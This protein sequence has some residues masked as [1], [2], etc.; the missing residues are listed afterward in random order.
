[1]RRREID[2]VIVW[3]LDHWGRSLADL[4]TTLQELTQLGIGFIS[5]N[6]ALD[7]TTPADL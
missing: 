2:V 7:L 5:Q 1:V 4:V 3:R 6:E